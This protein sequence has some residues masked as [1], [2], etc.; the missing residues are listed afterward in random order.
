M[1]AL[2]TK[3]RGRK[4]WS[5]S[6]WIILDGLLEFGVRMKNSDPSRVEVAEGEK[7]IIVVESV[8]VLFL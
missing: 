3:G 1:E 5:R 6:I 4:F 2:T 7:P 8:S